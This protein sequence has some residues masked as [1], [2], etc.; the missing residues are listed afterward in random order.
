MCVTLIISKELYSTESWIDNIRKS[1]DLLKALVPRALISI[2]NNVDVTKLRKLHIYPYCRLI[3]RST[4]KKVNLKSFKL[5]LTNCR[6]E[7]PCILNDA[8]AEEVTQKALDYQ[9][10]V[11]ELI[12]SGVYD[13]DD[14]FTV[15]VQQFI[16]GVEVPMIV[17]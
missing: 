10:A 2:V 16:E 15:V 4:D 5:I 7:C 11:H 13:T 3:R 8:E 6:F 17:S 9:N 1:L 12:N 14:Q